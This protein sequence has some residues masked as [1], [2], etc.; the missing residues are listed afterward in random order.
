M[1]YTT[2][3]SAGWAD[4]RKERKF[5]KSAGIFHGNGDTG[6]GTRR[7]VACVL[8]ALGS[9]AAKFCYG[10][11]HRADCFRRELKGVIINWQKN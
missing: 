4:P 5:N 2:S 11:S 9:L 7:L 6:S 1:W 3:I 8:C 10:I